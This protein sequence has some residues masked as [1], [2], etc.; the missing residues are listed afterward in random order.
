[1]RGGL[2]VSPRGR[3]EQDADEQHGQARFGAGQRG[4][5]GGLIGIF[6]A[7]ACAAGVS[8]YLIDYGEEARRFPRPIA[9]RRAARVGVT[10]GALFMVLGLVLILV[11][12]R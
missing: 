5:V 1:L 9:M 6:A 11:L 4:R 12:F 8:A 10:A 7:L 3:D 2:A